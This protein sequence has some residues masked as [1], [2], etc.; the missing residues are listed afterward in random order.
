MGGT[1]SSPTYY[2]PHPILSPLHAS[3]LVYQ[4]LQALSHSH[5]PSPS[6]KQT[7]TLPQS[8]QK[9]HKCMVEGCQKIFPTKSRLNRHS[10]VHSGNKPFKCQFSKCNKVFSRKDNMLQHFKSHGIMGREG[11]NS[12]EEEERKLLELLKEISGKAGERDLEEEYGQHS[13]P[14]FSQF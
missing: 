14:T 12:K 7:E 2:R 11:V 3:N 10:I 8:P 4:H 1:P 13:F 5:P 6:Q 9:I